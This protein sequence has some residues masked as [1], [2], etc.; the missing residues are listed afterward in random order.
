MLFVASMGTSFTFKEKHHANLQIKHEKIN[1]IRVA[2]RAY[3]FYKDLH[4][5]IEHR[6]TYYRDW[7]VTQP[8]AQPKIARRV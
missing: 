6:G 3:R 1:N 2:D 8:R 7:V 4:T 5:I